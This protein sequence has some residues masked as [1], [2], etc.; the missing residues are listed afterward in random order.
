MSRYDYLKTSLG[1]SGGV[2]DYPALSPGAGAIWSMS[3]WP[4]LRVRFVRGYWTSARAAAGIVVA[5]RVLRQGVGALL[6]TS[7]L[8]FPLIKWLG[9]GLP[10]LFWLGANGVPA[11]YRYEYHACGADPNCRAP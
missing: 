2:L 9:V 11:P 1:V 4:E 5:D 3:S 6:A 10:A 8:A 7:E